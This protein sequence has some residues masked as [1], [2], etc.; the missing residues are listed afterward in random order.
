MKTARLIESEWGGHASDVVGILTLYG[1]DTEIIVVHD[2]SQ[3]TSLLDEARTADFTTLLLFGE[4]F[5]NQLGQDLPRSIPSDIDRLTVIWVEVDPGDHPLTQYRLS[6]DEALEEAVIDAVGESP[7]LLQDVMGLID[8]TLTPRFDE[9]VISFEEVYC[10]DGEIDLELHLPVSEVREHF[11]AGDL[12]QW[13][14]RIV[15]QAD[16]DE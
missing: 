8:S 15:Q 4:G 13:L 5:L 1:I 11:N 6:T 10:Y 14:R 2:R 16:D 7:E 3:L 9:A 12:P